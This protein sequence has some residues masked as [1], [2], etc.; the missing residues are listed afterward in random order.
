M[1]LTTA[2][3]GDLV[4]GTL[5][6][7]G[8]PR[9]GQIAQSLVDY[10]VWTKWFKKD[11]VIFDSGQGIKRALMTKLSGSASFV[12]LHEITNPTIKELMDEITLSW[13]YSQT[14]WGFERR[15]PLMNRGKALVFNVI[16]PRRA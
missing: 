16:K 7:L 12:G 4:Q 2:Q 1:S 13:C 3:I 11:K 10:E 5:N 14:Y 15:E 6:N 9:F 8:P